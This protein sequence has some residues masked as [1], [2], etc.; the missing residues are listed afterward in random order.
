MNEVVTIAIVAMVLL[1]MQGA[2]HLYIRHNDAKRH[3][4]ER[5]VLMDRI[6]SVDYVAYKTIKPKEKPVQATT[7]VKLKPPDFV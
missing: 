7:E 1:T 4:A 5:Q 6:M 3:E 2:S